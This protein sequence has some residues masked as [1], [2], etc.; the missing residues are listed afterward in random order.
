MPLLFSRKNDLQ[1]RQSRRICA[2]SPLCAAF[3]GRMANYTTRPK[4]AVWALCALIIHRRLRNAVWFR[5]RPYILFVCV[6]FMRYIVGNGFEPFRF[7]VFRNRLTNYSLRKDLMFNEIY[8]R[9]CPSSLF[10]LAVHRC[11]TVTV[12][13]ATGDVAERS[14]AHGMMQNANQNRVNGWFS[15]IDLILAVLFFVKLG[16]AWFDYRKHGQF[17]IT[18]DTFAAL[19]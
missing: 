5:T 13:A 10:S 9:F 14:K 7:L 8:K 19:V 17:E 16:G 6:E 4:T 1:G 3:T 11:F 12:S 15:A 18:G 2:P